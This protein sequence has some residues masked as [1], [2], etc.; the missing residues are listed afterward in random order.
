MD[1]IFFPKI[2][3]HYSLKSDMVNTCS[4]VIVRQQQSPPS[5]VLSISIVEL[6]VAL[7][8]SK[9]IM[10]KRGYQ[11]HEKTKRSSKTV[12]CFSEFES[13]RIHLHILH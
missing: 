6:N 2:E 1:I 8:I 13:D 4:H 3:L 12:C 11:V 10:P 9:M 7:R 5:S